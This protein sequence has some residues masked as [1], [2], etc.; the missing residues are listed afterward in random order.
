MAGTETGSAMTTPGR[1]FRLDSPLL[2]AALGTLLFVLAAPLPGTRF[3]QT[4]ALYLPLHATLESF[5]VLVA[6]MIFVL[7]WIGRRDR[8]A[9]D[10]VLGCGFLAVGLIDFGHTLSYAGMPVFITPSG[11]EKAID[12]WLAAR[13]IAA[14]TLLAVGAGA[15]DRRGQGAA[16]HYWAILAALAATLAVYWVVL[17]H[18]DLP[19]RTFIAG[20]GLTPVKIAAE[21][22]IVVLTLAAAAGLWRRYRVSGQVATGY[23]AAAAWVSGLGEL[24]FTVYANVTDLYNLLGH[25]FKVFGYA[26]I[27]RALVVRLI[28]E[29][30]LLAEQ[31]A[32]RA[33]AVIETSMEGI[34]LVDQ[35]GRLV[36]CNAAF[37]A[38][39]GRDLGEMIGLPVS[40]WDRE[41][42]KH[43][44]KEGPFDWLHAGRHVIPT[45]QVRA[46]GSEFEAEVAISGIL[47]DDR[48]LLLCLSRDVTARKRAEA[49]DTLS[50]AFTHTHLGMLIADAE[51]RVIYVNPAFTRLTGYRSDEMLGQ[52]PRLLKS[53]LHDADFYRAMWRA[54]EVDGY[55]QG[56][57]RN[58]D[59]AGNLYDEL[60]T[61]SRIS[62][63]QGRPTH[64]IGVFND[65]TER[66]LAE[67]EL[68]KSKERLNEA[69][70]IAQVGSW[71]LD[72]VTNSLSW[73]DEIFHLFEIDQ[74]RFGATYEAFL[75]A[76]HPDDRGAVNA[77]YSRSLETRQ[78]YGITH[79]LLMPDGRIKFVHEQCETQYD[80]EGRPLRSL[81]TVQDVTERKATEAELESYREHLE[82]LVAERTLELDQARSVAEA[83]SRAKSTFLANMS[84]ELRT[85]MNAIMGMT[86]LALRRAE[87]PKLR[88]QLGKID[89]A[90]QHLLHVINDILDISKIEAERLVL[91][92]V[93]FRLGEVVENLLSIAGHKARD[94]GLAIRVE[95]AP[96]LAGRNL[97]GDPL[98]LGQV[99]LNL[100]SNAVKFTERGEVS[101]RA[102]LVE[103]DAGQ[104]LLRWE[105]Q[106]TGIG[107]TAEDQ[108]RLFTA[109]EQADGSMTRRYGGTG[110]GLAISK[111]LVQLM[112]GE[113]GL[114]SVPG[115]GSTF[116]FTARL[117]KTDADAT[118]ATAQAPDHAEA[119][120]RGRH[121]G[122]RV[123]LAEDEPVNREV[124]R[125]LIEDVGLV[126]D[127]AEDGAEAVALAQSGRYD[128]ILMDMQMPNLNGID[129]TRAIRADSLNTATPI[130]A[131]TANAFD[132][133][134]QACLDAG[135]DDHIAKPV[136]PDRLFE[137]LLRWLAR[138]E[139]SA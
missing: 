15:L 4:S 53:G 70:R 74:T 109:F 23:L 71:E 6:L 34:Y 59:K 62:D 38:M 43:L 1:P 103:E 130:L 121:A 83:A 41:I 126:V 73:S 105:V 46:D 3:I 17:G 56:E 16:F 82:E 85:P 86:G 2:W 129:A 68:R 22:V 137:T 49:L 54:I 139:A 97:V 111:R 119:R 133:D 12:F 27:F 52:T 30:R 57:I 45:H 69:Q 101:V 48:R 75:A 100:T 13:F 98:R 29:P 78:P 65:I 42:P 120:L 92:A 115:Q 81:G 107:I 138:A 7:T 44:P 87:D 96:G 79:R 58:R 31:A 18:P 108:K 125:G 89:Q 50:K 93:V 55:W 25:L 61:I 24:F 8:T 135:M 19:P 117:G 124:S 63:S 11:T 64:Y 14:F 102:R 123:L 5:S 67:A 110:L 127:L 114:D 40:A 88:D 80:A 77:A 131:M 116:W 28:Q 20:Q 60:I 134:R 39:L 51:E 35:D 99:L 33:R 136:D 66:K 26:L 21:A 113:I 106:D 32:A 94:K 122:A 84:H 76:I 36:E 132:E 104:V 128:L 72:L 10:I 91:E 112:G 95:L 118:R 90:S 47:R 9:A 37:A